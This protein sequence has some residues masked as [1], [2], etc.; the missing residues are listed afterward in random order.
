MGTMVYVA[1]EQEH[2]GT[3][4]MS[5]TL[6]EGAVDAI[7]ELK[8]MD[9]DTIMLTGDSENVAREIADEIGIDRYMAELLPEEKVKAIEELSDRGSSIMIGDGINDAPALAAADVGIA[10][11]AVSSDAALETSDIA[12]MQ[13]DLRKIPSLIKKARK[14]MSIVRQ[15]VAISISVK[16]LVGILAALGLVNLWIAIGVGDMGLTLAVIVNALRLVR[17]E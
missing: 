2:L 1:Q 7:D 6:R 16:L 4:V 14:T 15:N 13:Q 11:G 3:I 17:K 10:M 5:D 8:K 12:L 9:I